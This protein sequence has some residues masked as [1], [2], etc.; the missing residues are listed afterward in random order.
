MSFSGGDS[1]SAGK[2]IKTVRKRD[3]DNCSDILTNG[4]IYTEDAQKCIHTLRKENTGL[5]L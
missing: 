1:E 5:K 2:E 3:G 4:I